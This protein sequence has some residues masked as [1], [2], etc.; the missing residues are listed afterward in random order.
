MS[1]TITF[2]RYGE[3]DVLTVATTEVPQPGP[4]QVRIKVRAV[5]VNPIDAKI[6][7]GHLDGIFPI[8]LPMTPGW[9]VAGV[10]DAAG[11]GAGAAPGDEVFGVA[12]VGGYSE[13]ALLDRPVARP[14]SISA[15]TA[16][17]LVTVGEAAYRGLDRLGIKPGQT[18]LIHGAA[19]SVGTI[20]V[21][22][23]VARGITVI[24]TA[25]QNDVDRVTALGATAVS[26]GEG[27][28][29][30]V[31]AVAPD[32]VDAVFDTSG[33]GVLAESVAL[34]G[35]A[36]RVITIADEAAAEYGVR[37]TGADPAD[38]CPEA[39]PELVGLAAA[40]RLSVP[41]WRAYPLAEAARAHE[42]LEAGRNH[43]KIVLLP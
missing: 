9:D 38:R 5:A 39:L 41:I 22:L 12:S 11:P 15:Q 2:S 20:A 13:Y 3:P 21:Q 17:A 43:G 35:D 40:G 14:E 1:T 42:D 23:A 19:G 33:A 25:A 36:A 28:A 31:R 7:S 8:S 10:V 29:D 24:G 27:W 26:Y 37:F 4:G 32:G 6:R 16:A 30:R 34:A 18:L